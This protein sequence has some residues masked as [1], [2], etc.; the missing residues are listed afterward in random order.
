ME[1]S[2]A[3]AASLE[4]SRS[5]TGP[6][7]LLAR[8]GRILVEQAVPLAV[9]LS[10]LVLSLDAWL[11]SRAA[12]HERQRPLM[13]LAIDSETVRTDVGT[14]DVVT[15]VTI[16]NVGPLSF[17]ILDIR[18]D[19]ATSHGAQAD[20]RLNSLLSPSDNAL[21]VGIQPFRLYP[22]DRPSGASFRFEGRKRIWH[23]I[24]P[25][26]SFE[27][28]LVQPVRGQG[29]VATTITVYT[30][31]IELYSIEGQIRSQERI[32]GVSRTVLPESGEGDLSTMPIYPFSSG[33]IVVI[34]TD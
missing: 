25:G 28:M 11:S 32:G 13:A 22:T 30:Q 2:D 26:R 14:H 3:H 9:A 33:N 12:E 34:G 21:P 18:V 29:H 20:W 10:S 16:S 5:G 31:Q 15:K 6:P 17:L 24:D 19:M 4:A 7:G 1:G 23:G 8:I 27:F